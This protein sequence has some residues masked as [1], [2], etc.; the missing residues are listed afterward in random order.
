MSNDP[1]NTTPPVVPEW[2]KK[3]LTA[4]CDVSIASSGNLT[5]TEEHLF[6]AVWMLLRHRVGRTTLDDAPAVARSLVTRA[7]AAMAAEARS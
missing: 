1:T 2:A 3:T 6:D 5:P 4:L 7:A